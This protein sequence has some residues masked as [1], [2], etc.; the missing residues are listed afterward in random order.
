MMYKK[1]EVPTQSIGTR[2][3]FSLLKSYFDMIPH[4]GLIKR[5]SE[6]RG[7]D[8]EHRNQDMVVACCHPMDKDEDGKGRPGFAHTF[9][10]ENASA[11]TI[12]GIL[13][14]LGVPRMEWL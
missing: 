10:V 14:R 1:K 3:R 9:L 4:E 8:A 13:Q 2:I 6:K 7:S 5:L 12:N 11:D